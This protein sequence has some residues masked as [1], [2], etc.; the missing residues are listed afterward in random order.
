[1]TVY[2]KDNAV[3]VD[4]KINEI[5]DHLDSELNNSRGWGINI[6]HRIYK[7]SSNEGVL[8]HAHLSAK[9]YKLVF[10]NDR[11]N[12]EIGFVLSDTREINSGISIVNCDII[13]SLNIEKI[14]GLSNTR[15]DERLINAARQALS[16]Y[17]PSELKTGIKNVYSEFNTSKIIYADMQPFLNFS[18][19]INLIYL[20]NCT[21]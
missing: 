17:Y 8:P 12:G 19:N 4:S 13:F 21:I 16:V 1:M 15:E 7:E 3:G 14:L 6:Y 11:V 20:E 18:Y 5:I 9:D 10:N 2:K